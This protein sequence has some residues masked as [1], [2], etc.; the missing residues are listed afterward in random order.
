MPPS[1]CS[2]VENGR[3]GLKVS[4]L[5]ICELPVRVYFRVEYQHDFLCVCF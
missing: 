3:S 4:V 2:G 1:C 5:Q